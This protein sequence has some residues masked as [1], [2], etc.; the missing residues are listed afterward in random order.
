[1]I[2]KASAVWTGGLKDGKGRV[3]TET[4]VLKDVSYNFSQRFEDQPG[5][6][7]EELVAAAHSACYAMALA[8][9]LGKANLQPESVEARAKLTFEKQDVGFTTTNIH[10]EVTAKVSGIGQEA[11]LKI[12]EEAKKG[13]PISRLLNTNITLDAKLA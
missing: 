3:S 7:P 13:C 10:L 4:G 11:F 2:R 8:G 9:A 6:N 1:M 12:A 5:T